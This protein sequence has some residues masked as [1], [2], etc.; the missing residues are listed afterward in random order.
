VNS[1]IC[2]TSSRTRNEGEHGR[3]EKARAGPPD[4][5]NAGLVEACVGDGEERGLEDEGDEGKEEGEAR[6]K[7]VEG[8]TRRPLV[9]RTGWRMTMARMVELHAIRL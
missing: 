7:T 6:G 4:P 1:S 9:R 3:D 8:Y 5:A 2:G